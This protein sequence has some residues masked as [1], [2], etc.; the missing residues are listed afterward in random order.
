MIVLRQAGHLDRMDIWTGWTRNYLKGWT[1]KVSDSPLAMKS[2]VNFST[3]FV[4]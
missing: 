3:D 2:F 1:K 4:T